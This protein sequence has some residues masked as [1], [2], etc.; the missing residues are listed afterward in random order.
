MPDP[1]EL[2]ATE[3]EATCFLASTVDSRLAIDRTVPRGAGTDQAPPRDATS[4][5]NTPKPPNNHLRLPRL[6][7]SVLTVGVSSPRV[8]DVTGGTGRGGMNVDDR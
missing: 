2:G 1:E 6:A 3:V 4:S 8:A 7:P 5:R